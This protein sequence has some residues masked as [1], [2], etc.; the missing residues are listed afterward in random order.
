MN[1]NSLLTIK[2][3]KLYIFMLKNIKQEHVFNVINISFNVMN[4]LNCLM[5]IMQCFKFIVKLFLKSLISSV[6][7]TK[8]NDMKA[9]MKIIKI[10]ILVMIIIM[11]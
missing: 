6:I 8:I 9:L 5:T 11:F 4:D 2:F 10:M 1:F 7:L 3:D